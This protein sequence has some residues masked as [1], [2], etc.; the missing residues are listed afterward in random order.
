M[1]KL[2]FPYSLPH[3]TNL[4]NISIATATFPANWKKATIRPLAKTKVM[5]QP[6]DTRPIAHLP[7]LSKV[8]ERLV[9]NQLQGY[10][11]VNQ[12]YPF[13]Y[14][15]QAG[16]RP[17]HSTQTALLGIFDDIRHAIDDRMLTFLILFDFSKAFDYIPHTLLLAKLRS[18][19]FTAYALRW[20]FAYLRTD[21]WR[22][23]IWEA[24][25]PTGCAQLQGYPKE[26]FLAHFSS[27]SSL[28]TFRQ[29]FS[30]RR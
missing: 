29:W 21:C 1:F 3:I 8:L 13:I 20:F 30:S 23:S 28:T 17:G 7:E 6:S 2:T 24:K 14:P 27:L 12:P 10:L 25:S 5:T 11:E 19:G 16:F 4:F 18:V 15:R 26:V 9:R 22:L